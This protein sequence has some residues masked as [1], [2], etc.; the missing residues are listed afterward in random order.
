MHI[1]NIPTVKKIDL[2]PRESSSSA[3]PPPG[4]LPTGSD[5]T[6]VPY[7]L[8]KVLLGSTRGAGRPRLLALLCSL[9]I[10]G[11]S[12][13]SGPG[14]F[15]LTP[16]LHGIPGSWR[17]LGRFQFFFFYLTRWCCGVDLPLDT[18]GSDARE[19]LWERDGRV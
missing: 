16:G 15:P 13:F 3:F 19:R 17:H 14:S 10:S 2:M 4:P 18:Q 1:E 12:P 7:V 8:A 11:G 5:T 6:S 9:F